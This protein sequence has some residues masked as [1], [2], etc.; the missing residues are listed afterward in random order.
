[1]KNVNG[2]A[3]GK[4][5]KVVGFSD[6][7]LIGEN[8]FFGSLE[9][10]ISDPQPQEFCQIFLSSEDWEV[11]K[12]QDIKFDNLLTLRRKKNGVPPCIGD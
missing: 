8:P 1:M 9:S 2:I 5:K 11:V 7:S 10:D 12:S 6:F 3:N 4:K